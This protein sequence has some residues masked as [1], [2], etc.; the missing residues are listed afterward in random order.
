MLRRGRRIEGEDQNRKLSVITDC[1]F[2]TLISVHE[3]IFNIMKQFE[4]EDY[5]QKHLPY[6][7]NCLM[8]RDIMTFRRA[9]KDS[10]ALYKGSGYHPYEDSIVIEPAF[11]I[12]LVF[13]RVLLQFIGI[14]YNDKTQELKEFESNKSDDVTLKSLFPERDYC[15]VSEKIIEINKDAICT[16]MKVAN[17]SVAHLSKNQS[18]E[19]ELQL[20]KS[21]KI[22]VYDLVLKYVPEIDPNKLWYNNEVINNKNET[23]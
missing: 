17:K 7:L 2:L 16:L 12:S 13:G 23:S 10:D 18:N 20:L 6:R 19:T 11:E 8:A 14:N 4:I 21:A 1:C 3:F 9:K 15:K 22:A 5:I